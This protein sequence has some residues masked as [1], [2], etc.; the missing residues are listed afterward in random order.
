MA[1]E[2]ERANLGAAELQRVIRSDAFRN[3]DSL[4][5]LVAYLGEKSLVNPG[6]DVKEYT[7]GIEACG[8]PE[9]YDPQKDASVRV[10]MGR[11]RHKLE[12][13]YATEGAADPIVL[14][15]PKGRFVILFHERQPRSA[16]RHPAWHR[17]RAGASRLRSMHRTTL[18]LLVLLIAA[19]AWAAVLTWKIR[20]YEARL[21]VSSQS[22]IVGRFAP[23]WAPF[24]SHAVPTVA[25]FGSPP[26]FASGKHS[27]FV[28]LYS[29]R[30]ADDPRSSPEFGTIDARIGPLAGPRYDYA[31]MGDA[32]AVQR[33]TAFFGS[34]GFA[35]RASPAHLVT[36]DSI[37]DGNLIFIG[38]WRMHPLLRKLPIEQDFELGADEQIHN[39]NRKPGEQEVYTTKSHRDVMTYAVVG[40]YPGLS[41]RREVLVITAHS[42]PGAMAAVEFI[43]SPGGIEVMKQRIGLSSSGSRKYFQMLLRVHVDNDL[44]VKTEYATHHVTP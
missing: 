29:Q 2:P 31:S 26:F 39:R 28:R 35:L 10:Q 22:A 17:I 43:T 34:A 33:L 24:F 6:E 19:V 8:K 41:H 27:L 9:S 25:V 37:K 1:S 20:D 4:R 12:E 15:L 3:S 36:W 40:A 18:A 42:S 14:E 38:A 5:H 16:G 11:L 13:Y 44:P 30:N 7:I 23:L 32:V 21:E